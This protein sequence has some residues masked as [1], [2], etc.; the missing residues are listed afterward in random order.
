VDSATK[1]SSHCHKSG[2]KGDSEGPLSPLLKVCHSKRFEHLRDGGGA[3]RQLL[4]K[5]PTLQEL[6]CLIIVSSP[7]SLITRPEIYLSL[8]P[9]HPSLRSWISSGL[10][11]FPG[12]LI[13]LVVTAR[14]VQAQCMLTGW[15]GGGY[16]YDWVNMYSGSTVRIFT[17]GGR[18]VQAQ[19]PFGVMI[20]VWVAPGD[21]ALDAGDQ[22]IC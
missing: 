2:Y 4:F 1:H 15:M 6:P 22:V 3:I 7:W 17:S 12:L 8:D 20:G 21:A 19:T 16:C 9:M 5:T 10:L 13:S 11:V 14:P 18:D